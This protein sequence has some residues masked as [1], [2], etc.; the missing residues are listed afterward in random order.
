MD[1]L[2]GEEEREEYYEEEEVFEEQFIEKSQPKKVT[3]TQPQMVARQ[4]IN[5]LPPVTPVTAKAEEVIPEPRKISLDIT[6]LEERVISRGRTEFSAPIPPQ[7][8][9]AKFE[10]EFSP[11]ISPMFGANEKDVEAVAPMAVKK[12][13]AYNKTGVLS[14]IHGFTEEKK[15][16]PLPTRV[17]GTPARSQEAKQEE[18]DVVK[19]TLDE[20]LSRTASLSA[21]TNSPSYDHKE[22]EISSERKYEEKQ[23]INNRNMSLFDEE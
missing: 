9:K 1:M 7:P 20:I 23:V 6:E 4:T 13:S 10:Y 16:A 17:L 21:E 22:E 18:K 3:R 5:P 19:L 12:K 14:P 11:V 15:E 8:K 2:F